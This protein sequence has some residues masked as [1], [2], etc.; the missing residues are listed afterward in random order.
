M[1]VISGETAS[2]VSL[3]F[4]RRISFNLI[5]T[6]ILLSAIPVILVIL[7][8]TAL[9]ERQVQAQVYNQL[10]ALVQQK[11]RRLEEWL[12]ATQSTLKIID[13]NSLSLRRTLLEDEG[14]GVAV[15]L[16]ND[17]MRNVAE[18]DL[19]ILALFLY[20]LDGRVIAASD[21]SYIG[22][23]VARQPYFQAS[24]EADDLYVQPPFY[25]LTENSLALVITDTIE[26][27][28]GAPLGIL[29]ALMDTTTLA[30]IMQDYIG[31]G[32]TGETI[33]INGENNYMLTPSR[34]PN[35]PLNRAYLSEG[36]ADAL[37]G[38]Q[39]RDI[40]NDYRDVPVIAS[41]NYIPALNS[42][43]VAKIDLVEAFA[44]IREIRVSAGIITAFTIVLAA[45]FGLFNALRISRPLTTLTEIS[46]KMA[47]GDLS[48]RVQV[49]GITNEVG[50]LG[51][52]FNS[53]ADSLVSTLDNLDKRALEAQ[54]ANKQLKIANAKTREATRL[55]SE[56]LAN[57]SHE[58]RT[59][60]NAILGFSGIMLEGF[61]GEMD[62]EARHMTSR[63][64]ENS[65]GL[66]SLINDILD[67]AKIES[68]RIDLVR[69]PMSPVELAAQWK[70]RTAVLA[71]QKGLGFEVN[72]DESL[73]PTLYGDPERLSQIG[74]NLLSNA[75]KFT[76]T[77]KVTLTMQKKGLFWQISVADTGIGIPP[78]ALHYIFDEFRQVDG[79]SMRSYGGTGLGLAITRKL[80]LMM[81]GTIK[82]ESVIGKGA[83]FTVML[84]LQNDA[85]EGMT[86]KAEEIGV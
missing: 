49:S 9:T 74:I 8:A 72:V 33:L 84:P 57:M 36:I 77:G 38:N 3:P 17:Y 79:T 83:V 14:Q 32:E 7:V 10:D 80:V 50:L 45:G 76:D 15:G 1:T 62:E 18:D 78:H 58:L 31:L 30:T 11:T 23:T 22:R 75:F 82:V 19:N 68:G 60:L 63:V 24:L 66:L 85:Y 40:Y 55:K 27:D 70:S 39:G 43:I 28:F 13:E 46:S 25:D 6:A 16:A 65:Q 73:P 47:K 71:E 51:E 2:S 86:E 20:D 5:S 64:Y 26:G 52:T 81:N 37:A 35:Y 56:F 48:Q 53:M 41:Y 21:L 61:A 54:E 69:Q 44:V 4:W 67:I 29:A 12:G 34:T 59:P 42:A